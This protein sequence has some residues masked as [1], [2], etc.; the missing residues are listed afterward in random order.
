[1]FNIVVLSSSGGGN[2]EVVAQNRQKYGYE[3]LN[4][5]VDRKCGAIE[6]AEKYGIQ[7]NV[8]EK[9]DK[10]NMTERLLEYIPEN[11]DLIILLG[12]LSIL[13]DNFI[14]QCGKKIINMH[15]SL[16]PK[17]G[18]KGMYGIHVHEAVM[19]NKEKYTGCTVHYVTSDVDAGEII[20]QKKIK[21]D[22]NKT[23]W[24][25]GGDV[26]KLEN[27]MIIEVIKILMNEI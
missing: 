11:T 18:G 23:P 24:Q 14:E 8:V 17:Y 4:L 6:K 25:L 22:Y 10:K 9:K 15:P 19:Q 12:W 13:E 27:E 2:F 1:M 20:L 3:I 26:F 16:L 7:Y 21:V 5:I